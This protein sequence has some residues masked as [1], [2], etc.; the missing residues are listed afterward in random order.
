MNDLLRALLHMCV[1]VFL[2]ALRAVRHVLSKK[3][4]GVSICERARTH[5]LKLC[6][7][8]DTFVQRYLS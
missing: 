3:N 2:F 7:S 6:L 5:A 4:D 8:Q 1:C